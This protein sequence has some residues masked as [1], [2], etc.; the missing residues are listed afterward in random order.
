MSFDSLLVLTVSQDPK[1][2]QNAMWGKFS[3]D[4][5]MQYVRKQSA[6]LLE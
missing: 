4:M 3:A 6:K 2:L 1:G 5:L